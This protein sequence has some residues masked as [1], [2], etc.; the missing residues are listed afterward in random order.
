MDAGGLVAPEKSTAATG[1]SARQV[2][3]GGVGDMTWETHRAEDW[4]R[5]DWWRWRSPQLPQVFRRGRCGQAAQET[6]VAGDWTPHRVHRWSRRRCTSTA[7]GAK[8]S[9]GVAFPRTQMEWKVV[10]QHRR[11][12][13][14]Q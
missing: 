11:R 12:R 8:T 7:A 6:G 1:G 14:A 13:E 5:E 4:T 10:R 2:R 9:D 3:T